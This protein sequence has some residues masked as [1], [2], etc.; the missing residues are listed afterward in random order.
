MET[1]AVEKVYNVEPGTHYR[2]SYSRI[3]SIFE[4]QNLQNI[5]RLCAVVKLVISVSKVD[6]KRCSLS[7]YLFSHFEPNDYVWYNIVFIYLICFT[8]Y[9]I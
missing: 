5:R 9:Y 6:E 4:T 8:T 2:P 3:F 7:M 1:F